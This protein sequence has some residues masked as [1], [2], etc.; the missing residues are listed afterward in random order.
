MRTDVFGWFDDISENPAHDPGRD[1]LCAVCATKIGKEI[2]NTI[3][4]MP[5]EIR[6]KSYFFRVHSLCWG[7]IT[8]LEKN[9][10]ESSLI[11]EICGVK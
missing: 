4:L 5:D 8:E 6:D 1:G 3:S 2:C 7:S 11:D 9:F 10:I